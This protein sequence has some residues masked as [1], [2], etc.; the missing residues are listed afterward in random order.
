MLV[1]RWPVV[2]GGCGRCGG[3]GG[4][5][6]MV[7]LVSLVVIVNVAAVLV[8]WFTVMMEYLRGY[9]VLWWLAVVGGGGGREAASVVSGHRVEYRVTSPFL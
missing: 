9:S 1:G 3:C 5:G 8:A 4:Y 2:R 7:A 6:L